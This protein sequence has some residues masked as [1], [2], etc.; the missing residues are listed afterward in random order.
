MYFPRWHKQ[1][2]VIIAYLLYT[3]YKKIYREKNIL[4]FITVYSAYIPMEK[5]CCLSKIGTILNLKHFPVIGHTRTFSLLHSNQH[6]L[7]SSS[8]TCHMYFWLRA[9]IRFFSTKTTY[10]YRVFPTTIFLFF[11]QFSINGCE[12]IIRIF[13]FINT[14]EY[15]CVP[16]YI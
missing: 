14:I 4:H 16:N 8:F 1:F 5:C 3:N 13:F 15:I 11:S 9:K 12:R 2:I 6:T 10:V 7:S